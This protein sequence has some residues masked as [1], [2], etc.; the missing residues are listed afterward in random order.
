LPKDFLL[1]DAIIVV[2]FA[3][4]ICI[5]FY[6]LP[7]INVKGLQE[8]LGVAVLAFA[9][10]PVVA[11]VNATTRFPIVKLCGPEFINQG[12]NSRY[13]IGNLIGTNGQWVYLSEA[14]TSSSSP[15]KFLGSYIAVIPLSAVQLESIGADASCGD[16]HAPATPAG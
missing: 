6:L 15:D 14:V 4:V 7:K 9:F 12:T 8:I 10:I 16:L 3:I 5:A 13:A 11:S 1:V 2:A